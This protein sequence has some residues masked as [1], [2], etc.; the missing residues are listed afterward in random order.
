ESPCTM[1]L[2]LE[3]LVDGWD[4]AERDPAS[5]GFM[6]DML[7]LPA[8]EELCQ[9]RTQQRRAIH[10]RVPR[11]VDKLRI[12]HPLAQSSPAVRA[13][14]M[15]P[16]QSVAAVDDLLGEGRLAGPDDAR[17]SVGTHGED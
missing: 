13:H 4:E 7:P 16:D 2:E 17:G 8:P 15:T 1:L 14:H 5:L 6:E 3:K 9:D 12:A 10:R 11:I